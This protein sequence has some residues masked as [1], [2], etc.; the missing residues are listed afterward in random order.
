[1]K[2]NNLRQYF[3]MLRTKQEIL[4]E[5]YSNEELIKLFNS[6]ER[7][8]QEEFLNICSGAKGIKMLYDSFFKEVFNPE[9]DPERLSNLLSTLMGR[10]VKFKFILPNDTTRLGDELSLVITDIVVELEDGTIA[11]VEV[12]KLGYAFTGERA[13]CYSADLLLRQYKRIRDEKKKKFTYKDV[14]PVYT[15]VFMEKS[16]DEFHAFMNTYIHNINYVSNTGLKLNM[17]QNFMFIPID[18]FLKKLHNNGINN[19][20]DAWLTFLGCDEPEYIVELIQ[21]YPYF[22]KFYDDIYEMCL[23]VEG[24]MSM[25]SKELQILDQNT[26]RYM[27]DELQEKLDVATATLADKDKVIADN[28]A[29]LADKDVTIKKLQEELEKYKNA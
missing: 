28:I 24:V 9:Y 10:K 23:N 20:L 5:I 12:Q 14:A 29:A 16:S 3:P 27:I 19:E 17:L 18:I 15:I 26:V 6:W 13:S 7:Y 2:N 11:N 22:K 21:K 4:E 8:Q 1:M 25:F